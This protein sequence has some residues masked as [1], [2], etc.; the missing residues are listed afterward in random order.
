MPMV[1]IEGIYLEG[2]YLE[3]TYFWTK[4]QLNN[5]WWL[6]NILVRWKVEQQKFYNSM[7]ALW[8]IKSLQWE[9]VFNCLWDVQTI[10]TAL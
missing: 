8:K 6:P 1:E 10:Q 2:T 7:G 4:I 3:G 9:C 5:M